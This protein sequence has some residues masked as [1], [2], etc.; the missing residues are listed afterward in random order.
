MVWSCDKTGSNKN[1]RKYV[2]IK[3]YGDL[4]DDPNNMVQPDTEVVKM[5][6]LARNRARK[7]IGRKKRLETLRPSTRI[8]RKR[9]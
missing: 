1:T 6:D 4:W 2:R 8:K 9:R 5:K 3:I 7:V